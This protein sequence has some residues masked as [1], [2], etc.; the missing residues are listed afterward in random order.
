M[1]PQ[2][3]QGGMGVHISTPLLANTVARLGGLG[4]VSGVAADKMLARLLQA[5][6]A[7]GHYRRALSHFPFPEIARWVLDEY[8]VSGGIPSG[9]S[10]KPVPAVTLTS[11]RFSTAMLICGNYALVW[12]AK[13]GHENPVSINWLEKMQMCH[14]GSIF[15][16]MLAEVDVI[17]MGAGIPIQ[18]PRVIDAYANGQPAEY[19]VTVTGCADGTRTMRFD[20]KEFFGRS[21][22]TLKRPSFLPIVSAD[23]LASIMIKKTPPGSIQ[24]FVVEGPTA[25][26]H[27]APP[28]VQGDLNTFGEP[29]YGPRDVPDFGK[30]SAM[31]VPFWIGGSCASPAGLAHALS[32]GARGIQV[33][34]LFAL[35]EESGMAPQHRRDAIRLW[36][37]GQLRIKQDPRASPT[38]FPFQV[39]QLP[40]TLADET[41]YRARHRIC[42][43]HG[44][45]T[46]HQLPSGRI[47]YRCPAGPIDSYGR[48]GGNGADTEGARCLCNGLIATTGLGDPGEASIVTLGADLNFLRHLTEDEHS[49]YTV[50]QAMQYLLDST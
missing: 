23:I 29:I 20:P 17:T 34:S 10:Y 49:A 18:V 33:G 48:H 40:G 12:L 5:G 44:L 8:F 21:A 2:I 46:P 32:I 39:A 14:L 41:V 28:R 6:D 3:I 45:S 25:G 24:G 27:N 36:H 11:S 38:G 22:L 37:R 42:N 15:G 43:H 26:G 16:A 7:G 30:I 31:G 35:S 19:R 50:A 4:T 47:V 1:L 9:T 13:E